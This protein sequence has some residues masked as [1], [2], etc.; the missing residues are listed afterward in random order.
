MPNSYTPSS[1]TAMIR[2]SCAGI[3]S[4]DRGAYGSPPAAFARWDSGRPKPLSANSND[5]GAC[6]VVVARIPELLISTDTV[7][8]SPPDRAETSAILPSKATVSLSAT[9]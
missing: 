3:A 9:D 8:A 4:S 5:G 2:A 6:S 7:F 1:N